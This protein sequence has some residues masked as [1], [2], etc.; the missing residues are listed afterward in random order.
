MQWTLSLGGPQAQAL[1]I[2]VGHRYSHP[3]ARDGAV[4]TGG[5]ISNAESLEDEEHAQALRCRRH[6]G[7]RNEG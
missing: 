3:R 7:G 1:R 6:R 2:F 4:R 5:V